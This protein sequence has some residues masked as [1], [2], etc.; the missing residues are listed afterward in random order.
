MGREDDGNYDRNWDLDGKE[1]RKE[2]V[3][4]KGLSTWYYKYLFPLDSS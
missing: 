3:N 4:G 1:P 2:R